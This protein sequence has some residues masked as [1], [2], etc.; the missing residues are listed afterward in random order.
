MDTGDDLS[1]AAVVLVAGAGQ[2]LTGQTIVIDGGWSF[3]DTLLNY[4]VIFSAA[5]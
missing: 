5:V 1:G 3:G 2:W 4:G